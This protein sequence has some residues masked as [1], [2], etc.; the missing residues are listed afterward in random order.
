[1][2]SLI[3]GFKNAFR[4]GIRTVA[5]VIILG[6]SIGLSLTMLVARQ[7]VDNKISAVKSSIGNTVSIQPAGFNSYSAINNSLTVSQLADLIKIPNVTAVNETLTE[8]LTTIGSTDLS[9][10]L[11][12]TNSSNATTSLSSPVKLNLKRH[13]FK[14]GGG[15]FFSGGGS[16]SIPTNFSL[17]ITI[18]GTSNSQNINGQSLTL[19]QGN[20]FSPSSNSDL[21]IISSNMASKNNLK[22]GSTFQSYNVNFKVTGIYLSANNGAL[23]NAAIVP[24]SVE[25]SLSGQ[26]GDVTAAE[27]FV[28]S[29]DNLSSV[30]SAI[31]KELGSNVN[32]TN[33]IEDANT[34]VSPLNSVKT[35]SL[36]S[37]IGAIIAG[38][39][40]ILLTMIIVARERR[41]EIGIFKAIGASNLKIV[42]QFAAESS[43]L[44]LLG[45]VV[46]I[47]IVILAG[48]PMTK[49]LVSNSTTAGTVGNGRFSRL[50]SFGGGAGGRFVSGGRGVGGVLRSNI[51]NVH[52]VIGWDVLLYGILAV[53]I[54][55]VIGSVGI[56]LVISKVR[57]AE[58]MRT[59]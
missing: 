56:A 36:Y 30:T 27:I 53:I 42:S 1:M 31:Q 59:D 46:G 33:A 29:I 17:P 28:N 52:A 47:L 2:A 22:V 48:N 11:Q 57:P 45:A 41:K 55:S 18:I 39:I 6:V 51:T 3:R 23:G 4:S 10:G 37:V 54:I 49:F 12:S 40:I 15:L 14:A 38:G 5:I 24:L 20:Y 43:T 7:A 26:S 25:Q 34:E 50:G 58:I 35:I 32:V 21:A 16:S 9:F 44:T 19:E 8:R 13:L